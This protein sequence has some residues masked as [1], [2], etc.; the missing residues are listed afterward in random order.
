[1]P[2]IV[3][4]AQSQMSKAHPRCVGAG[5]GVQDKD[6]VASFCS[7]TLGQDLTTQ[8]L[9]IAGEGQ[10]SCPAPVQQLVWQLAA[11]NSHSMAQL[12]CAEQVLQREL[13]VDSSGLTS[14]TK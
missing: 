7:S 10:L 13:S 9:A 8:D 4:H 3:C 2:W 14:S 5:V 11:V 1:M 12:W 6:P